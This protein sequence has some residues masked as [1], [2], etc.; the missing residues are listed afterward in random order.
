MSTTNKNTLQQLDKAHGRDAPPKRSAP[1]SGDQGT[2]LKRVDLEKSTRQS[3]PSPE[4]GQEKKTIET[5]RLSINFPELPESARLDPSL[6]EDACPWYDDYVNYARKKEPRSYSGFHDIFGL[7]IMSTIVARRKLLYFGHYRHIGLQFAVVAPSSA[8]SKSGAADIARMVLNDTGLEWLYLSGSYTPQR[9]IQKM[10]EPV[11]DHE[12]GHGVEDGEKAIAKSLTGR[13]G[14]IYDEAAT[15]LNAMMKK[16]G[17]M[18]DWR[19][20]LK[21]TYDLESGY[22]SGTVSR[23]DERWYKPYLPFVAILTLDN[24]RL[25]AYS[26]SELWGDGQFPRFLFSCPPVGEKM[27]RARYPRRRPTEKSILKETPNRIT[28][29][30]KD[31]YIR[32]GIASV[33][34]MDDNSNSLRIN[35]AGDPNPITLSD[36]VWNASYA[37]DDAL[38]D[39]IESGDVPKD[40]HYSYVRF[41]EGSLRVAGLF[42]SMADSKTIELNHWV[43]ALGVIEQCRYS[44]HNLYEQANQ[45]PDTIDTI[46]RRSLENK[47]VEYAKNLRPC[48]VAIVHSRY[49]KNM[50]AEQITAIFE[51]LADNEI[52][53]KGLTRK[54]T[55]RYFLPRVKRRKRKNREDV[56]D[57]Y[58][59]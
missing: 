8:H 10:N 15:F 33:S 9:L 1:E 14:L 26:G 12:L 36:E 7:W 16:G 42:A 11:S 32:L 37:Y 58:K 23:G 47:F 49:E 45:H 57:E 50:T 25:H 38:K 52:L 19:R 27:S 13:R 59:K 31:W 54:N 55:L 5:K 21:K 40:L 35:L 53:E 51:S 56:N 4:N 17:Y 18:A 34:G 28:E 22:E 20:I 43:K 46:E 39:L 48:T 6:G 44:L 2:K 29:P 30:L 3:N 24:I 41:Q